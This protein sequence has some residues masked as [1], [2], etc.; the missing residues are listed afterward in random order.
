M[1]QLTAYGSSSMQNG[2][3]F[4]G[5]TIGL[6]NDDY[7]LIL[8]QNTFVEMFSQDVRMNVLKLLTEPFQLRCPSLQLG[9][10]RFCCPRLHLLPL[11]LPS[12]IYRPQSRFL[13]RVCARIFL[14]FLGGLTTARGRSC[15]LTR[16]EARPCS[17]LTAEWPSRSPVTDRTHESSTT[18]HF[19][20]CFHL[21]CTPTKEACLTINTSGSFLS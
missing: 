4:N 17:Y 2:F 8:V 5:N 19:G 12:E 15:T 18:V 11:D 20:V 14:G 7:I 6:V 3:T 13:R 1:W 9:Q 10:L 21:K 16:P